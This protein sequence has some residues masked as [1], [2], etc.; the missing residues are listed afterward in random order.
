MSANNMASCGRLMVEL[1]TKPKFD[2]ELGGKT[3]AAVVPRYDGDYTVTPT[4]S[5]QILQTA[6]KLMTDNL[7]ISAIPFYTVPNEQ[8]GQTAIIGR[9]PDE[10]GN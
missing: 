3:I 6:Q 7:T 9:S 1:G 8:G 2:A 4:S 5:E 10:Y